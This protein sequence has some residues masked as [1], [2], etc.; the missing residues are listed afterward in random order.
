MENRNQPINPI[1]EG[2]GDIQFKGLNKREYFAGLAMQGLLANPNGAMTTG[3]RR[4]FSP[5]E[6]SELA[7]IHTDAL[8]E[9]LV[10]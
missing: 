3:G 1:F 8:L 9:E 7:V 10:K 2:N 4:T 6:I 5:K